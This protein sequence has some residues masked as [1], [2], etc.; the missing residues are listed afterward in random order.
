MSRSGEPIEATFFLT[1]RIESTSSTCLADWLPRVRVENWAYCLMTNHFHL[2]LVPQDLD[3]L[4][5]CL[6]GVTFRHTQYF[7]GKYHRSGRLWQNRFFSCPVDLSTHLWIVARY[8]ERNPVRAGI[9][10]QPEAWL[11]SSARAHL[12]GQSDRFLT[13]SDWL[14]SDRDRQEYARFVTEAGQE[15]EVRQAT[16]TGRPLGGI[17]FYARLETLL[18]RILTR[19]RAGRHSKEDNKS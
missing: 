9:V 10:A 7:N 16:S 3:G 19:R 18:G 4:G 5:K 1:K 8:I 11:W 2:L 14:T 17:E 12:S 6:H 15:A 13:G